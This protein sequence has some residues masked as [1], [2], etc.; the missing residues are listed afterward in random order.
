MVSRL[1]NIHSKVIYQGETYYSNVTIESSTTTE[2]EINYPETTI[3]LVKVKGIIN[4]YDGP[5]YVHDGI[6]REIKISPGKDEVIFFIFLDEPVEANI[7]TIAGIPFRIRINFSRQPMTDFYQNKVLVIDPGH[8]GTDG[9]QRGPVNLWE[10]DT[11]W[12]TAMELVKVLKDFKAK[13]VLTREKDENP[14]WQER[15][16]KVPTNTLC[17]ISLHQYHSNDLSQRGTLVLYNELA[18]GNE[19][20]AN[21]VMESIIGRVKTPSLGVKAEKELSKL[22]ELPALKIKPVTITNWVDEGLLRNPNFY[23]KIA[24]ATSVGIKQFFKMGEIGHE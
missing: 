8:G 11:A 17:F 14:S 5:I 10:R 12:K 19:K 2:V 1:T 7:D 23:K 3:C 16:N 20:L 6:I 9:G 18:P 21:Q 22:G 13:V 15:I 24:L 4:M